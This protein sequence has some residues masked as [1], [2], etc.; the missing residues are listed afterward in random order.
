MDSVVYTINGT[1]TEGKIE[2]DIGDVL[3]ATIVKSAVGT[4]QIVL[5]ELIYS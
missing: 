3:I 1:T 2:V 5:E 4:A